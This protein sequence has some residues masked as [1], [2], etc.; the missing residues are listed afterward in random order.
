MNRMALICWSLKKTRL[1]YLVKQLILQET[2]RIPRLLEVLCK[3]DSASLIE[4]LN[5]S[6]MVSDRHLIIDV[7][8]VKEMMAKKEIQTEWIKGKEQVANFA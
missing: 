7:A 1:L 3:T 4:L 5:S 8:R 6:N 2:F